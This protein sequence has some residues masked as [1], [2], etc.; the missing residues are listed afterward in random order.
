MFHVKRGAAPLVHEDDAATFG[1]VTEDVS[2]E[3]GTDPH[4][5]SEPETDGETDVSRETY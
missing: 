4:L 5:P 2:R 3:T 1:H